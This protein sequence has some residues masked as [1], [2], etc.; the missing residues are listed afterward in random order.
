MNATERA[1]HSLTITIAS[2]RTNA[3]DPES[4]AKFIALLT[5]E[6]VAM[7][8]IGLTRETFVMLR[9]HG[10]AGHTPARKWAPETYHWSRLGRAV[11]AHVSA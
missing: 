7:I 10:L 9:H 1:A 4:V 8:K 3:S 5:D 11:H 6:E 2:V